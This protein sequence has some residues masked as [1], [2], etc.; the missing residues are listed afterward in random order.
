MKW[1]LNLTTRSKLFVGFG[2][3][4][5]FLATVIVTAYLGIS[6]LQASQKSLYQADFANALDLM[7]LRSNQNGVRA[8]QLTMMVVSDRPDRE[9]WRQDADDRR[10]EIETTMRSLLDRGR[11][12]PSLLARLEELKAIQDAL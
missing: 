5:V 1:F 11:H 3:M 6:A 10:K 4:I 12:D 7:N 8:A 2:L 9:R